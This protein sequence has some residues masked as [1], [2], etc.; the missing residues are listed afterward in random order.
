MLGEEDYTKISSKLLD[1]HRLFLTPITTTDPTIKNRA[2]LADRTQQTVVNCCFLEDDK[3]KQKFDSLLLATDGLKR[4]DKCEKDCRQLS[5]LITIWD[6]VF[7]SGIDFV[8]S[9]TFFLDWNMIQGNGKCSQLAPVAGL[10][11]EFLEFISIDGEKDK[12]DELLDHFVSSAEDLQLQQNKSNFPLTLHQFSSLLQPL[13]VHFDVNCV[14][15]SAVFVE[16]FS[17]IIQRASSSW[18][19][20]PNIQLLKKLS[21]EASSRVQKHLVKEGFEIGNVCRVIRFLLPVMWMIV[22]VDEG[23]LEFY[24][25]QRM[26]DDLGISNVGKVSDVLNYYMYL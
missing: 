19:K 5:N 23:E 24:E 7:F 20:H 4:S 26:R 6:A 22:N 9:M 18:S 25:V 10:V 11:A 15:E 21:N 2:Y 1:F 17:F 13:L 3:L 8:S 16:A 14:N 12:I